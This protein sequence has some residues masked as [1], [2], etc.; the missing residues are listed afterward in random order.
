MAGGSTAG[1]QREPWPEIDTIVVHVARVHDYLL[2]GKANFAVDR[3]AAEWAYAAWAGG[4]D[5][6]RADARAHRA[7][8]GRVV[9][10]L[11]AD[12]GIR[13]FLDIGTGS[14]KLPG[15]LPPPQRRARRRADRDVQPPQPAGERVGRVAPAGR[16]H[17]VLRR[18]RP[19]RT[20]GGAASPV[21]ARPGNRGRSSTAH[22]GWCRTEAVTG[23]PRRIEIEETRL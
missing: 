9:R 6:V 5:G 14:T 10:L 20:R 12:A 8:L 17:P 3:E 23:A 1:V 16:S 15:H 21:A 19:G 22:V 18:P 11:A 7:V 13:Q 4:L 2:G